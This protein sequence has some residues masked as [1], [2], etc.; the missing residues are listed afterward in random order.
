MIKHILDRSPPFAQRPITLCKVLY[1]AGKKGLKYE[2]IALHMG[3]TPEQ[4]NGVL[5]A[6][7]RR[8]NNTDGVESKLGVGYF[9]DIVRDVD[10]D[11]GSWGWSMRDELRQAIQNG[12]YS[13]AKDWK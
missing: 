8:I 9:F 10:E 6:L 4:L 1:K 11:I 5:G 7:G 2:D 12:N 3:I 13:W